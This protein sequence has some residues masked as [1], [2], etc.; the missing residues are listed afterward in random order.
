MRAAGAVT[1]FANYCGK[2]PKLSNNIRKIGNL[3]ERHPKLAGFISKV[4]KTRSKIKDT[5]KKS[6]MA[7][8][9]YKTVKISGKVAMQHHKMH[10]EA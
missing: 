5:Y 6:N 1:K 7:R 3:I 9:A 10:S 8:K 2:Y 4:S